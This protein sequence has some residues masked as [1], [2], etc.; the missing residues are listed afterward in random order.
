MDDSYLWHLTASGLA[1]LVPAGLLLVAASGL[2]PQRAWDAALGGLAAFCLGCV[3]YWAVGF[4]FQFGSVG[5]S[6]ARIRNL[7]GLVR[8]WIPLPEGWGIGW[9][10]AGLEGVVSDWDRRRLLRR[11]ACLCG[12]CAMGDVRGDAAGCGASGPRADGRDPVRRAAG[13]RV[14]LS[15]GGEL[16]SGGRMAGRIGP[17]PRTRARDGRFWGRRLC[18]SRG[19]VGKRWLHC[20]FGSL[21]A[22]RRN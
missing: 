16:D 2:R 15:A 3:G 21:P 22:G 12:A 9:I 5:F 17:E 6:T 10:A 4:A 13:R 1:F 20:W 7:A 8:G 14:C 19:R 11:L 18:F